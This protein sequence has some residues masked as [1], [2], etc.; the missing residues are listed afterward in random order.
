MKKII[1]SLTSYPKRI[2]MVDKVIK[3]LWKQSVTADEIILYLSE[4]EFPQKERELPV[5]LIR[6]IGKNGFK[7]KWVE[8][9]IRSHKKYFYVLQDKRDDIV[10]TV[11]DD[12][13]YS[14]TLIY[15]LVCSYKRFPEAVSARSARIILKDKGEV[16]EYKDWD[17]CL[18]N[19]ADMPR[20]DLCAIGYAGVLYPPSCACDRWFGLENI[21]SLACNQDDLWLKYNE[22][23]NQ[24][25][26]VYVKS[27]KNDILIDEA[28]E[29]ALCEMNMYYGND[30]SIAKLTMWIKSNYFDEWDKWITHIMQ[31][32]EY[33]LMKQ[34]DN[35]EYLKKE[36]DGFRDYPVYLYGAGKR[37]KYVLE[38][39]R[40][41]NLD[42]R[43][44]A[45]VVSNKSG[46][47]DTIDRKKVICIDDIDDAMPFVAIYGVGEAYKREVASVLKRYKC[48]CLDFNVI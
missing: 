21:E 9:N 36:L 8:E 1:V 38:I 27:V 19:Y 37:A 29:T 46:N 45:I 35:V 13:I 11:D 40:E 10:I 12:V 16:A 20:M 41:Y 43:I 15:D 48:T 31:K 44:E 23:I 42:D 34:K 25:P 30:A 33:F 4:T 14:E 2:S 28:E 18:D 47:P 6:M 22:I 39:L 26:V 32:K 24:I 17:Y 5:E 3:S 7:I